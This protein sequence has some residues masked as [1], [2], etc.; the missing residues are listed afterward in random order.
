MILQ[1]VGAVTTYLVIL[2]QFQLSLGKS[3][4]NV[5]TTTTTTSSTV[6]LGGVTLTTTFPTTELHQ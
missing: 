6:P 3:D 1:I 4:Q 2:I 5:T